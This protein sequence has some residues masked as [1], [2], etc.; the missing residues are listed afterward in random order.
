MKPV[1]RDVT[2][3]RLVIFQIADRHGPAFGLP[4][5]SLPTAIGAP[6]KPDTQKTTYQQGQYNGDNGNLGGNQ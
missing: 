1:Q 4:K 5:K 6:H 3:L 2:A